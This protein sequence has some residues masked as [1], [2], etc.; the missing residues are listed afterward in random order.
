MTLTQEEIEKA[1]ERGKS[2]QYR[3]EQEKPVIE[4]QFNV[5]LPEWDTLTEDQKQKL[6]DEYAR[7]D[8]ELNE[9]ADKFLSGAKF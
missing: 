7:Y 1:I 2:G 9:F 3:Y 5:K 6:R 8:A 4:E